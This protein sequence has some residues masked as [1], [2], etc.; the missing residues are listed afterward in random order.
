MQVC[1]VYRQGRREELVAR[2]K[3]A[4]LRGLKQGGLEPDAR[5]AAVLSRSRQFGG[6]N[7]HPTYIKHISRAHIGRVV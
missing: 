1:P 6:S 5:A 3:L 7:P 4:I 2:G